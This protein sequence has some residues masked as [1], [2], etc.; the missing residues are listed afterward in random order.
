MTARHDRLVR[1]RRIQARQALAALGRAQA[2]LNSE[3][4]LI[5]RVTTLIMAAAPAAGDAGA[6][7][8]KARGQTTA[9]LGA[10]ADQL[11]RRL[12]ARRDDR[13]ALAAALARAQAAV[14]AALARR[15]GRR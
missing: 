4:A 14:D 7:A 5:E 13:A 9:M 1:V 3:A 10:L 8:L 2:A 6:G 11:G 12:V 15:E